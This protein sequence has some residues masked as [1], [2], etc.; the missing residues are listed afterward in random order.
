[1][2]FFFFFFVTLAGLKIWWLSSFIFV[3]KEE[4]E[5]LSIFELKANLRAAR[6][7]NGK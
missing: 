1:M 3:M 5:D 6:G 4:A 7:C 2:F